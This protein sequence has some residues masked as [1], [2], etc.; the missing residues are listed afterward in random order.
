MALQAVG[1]TP[2]IQP[3]TQE[4]DAFFDAFSWQPLAGGHHHFWY[5]DMQRTQ[6]QGMSFLLDYNPPWDGALK[7]ITHFRVKL[8]SWLCRNTWS[9]GERD[10]M[11]MTRIG[12]VEAKRLVLQ[13]LTCNQGSNIRLPLD[14]IATRASFIRY[15]LPPRRPRNAPFSESDFDTRSPRQGSARRS[16][17]SSGPSLAVCVQKMAGRCVMGVGM[18]DD[19]W[20]GTLSRVHFLVR[21][22]ESFRLRSRNPANLSNVVV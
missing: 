18:E 15:V 13:A 5:R 3:Q 16:R 2:A 8:R 20:A 6:V 9:S 21:A 11:P 7:D 22:S 10:G 17:T 4:P 1:E 19:C 14:L 12:P